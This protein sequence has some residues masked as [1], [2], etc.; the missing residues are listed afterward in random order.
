MLTPGPFV[1]IS[2]FPID[3][4]CFQGRSI[5]HFQVSSIQKFSRRSIH[6][7]MCILWETA[8]LTSIVF[9]F[10]PS[11]Q[12]FRCSLQGRSIEHFQVSSIQKCSRRSFHLFI[13]KAVVVVI[14]SKKYN[15]SR[16]QGRSFNKNGQ[17]KRSTQ[18]F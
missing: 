12:Q 1:Q 4:F 9:K 11:S 14:M 3:R 15:K 16:F 2:F 7:F 10:R 8:F 18:K 17:L 13:Q 5:E 6:L